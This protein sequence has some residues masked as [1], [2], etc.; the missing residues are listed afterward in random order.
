M[1][2]NPNSG[3]VRLCVDYQRVNA[4]TKKDRHPLPLIQECFD[5][6]RDAKFFSKIDLQQ[7]FHQMRIADGDVPKTA[8]GTKYGHFEWLVMPFGLVNAPS[9]FQRMM[10]QILREF[11]DIFVQVYLDDILIYSRNKEDHL[12]HVEQ[13]LKVRYVRNIAKIAA[14]LHN[15]TAGGVLKW[16]AVSWFP[17]HTVAFAQLK[18]ALMSGPVLLMPNTQSPFVM[19][20]D[21]LDFA[22]G[23]VWLQNG[24]DVLLHPVA[25]ESCKLNKAQVDYP[26]QERELLAIIHAWRKWHVYLD[27]AVE[28]TIVYTDHASLK[29]LSTQQLPLKRICRW[30]EEFSKMD[31]EIRYKKGK[32]NVVPDALSRQGDLAVMEEIDGTLHWSDW[33]LIIP[34]LIEKRE[35][36]SEVPHEMTERA[37]RNLKFFE[38]N[39][40]DKTL[41]YLGHPGLRERL[42]FVA[43]AYCYNLL[44]LVHND[45][46]HQGRDSTLQLLRGREWWPK[47][48][49][50]VN[51]YVHTCAACQVHKRPHK[52][53]ETGLQKPLPVV[54]PFERWS[55]DLIQ[56]PKSYKSGYKWILTVVDPCTSWPV[57]V[58]L[59][60]A[61]AAE[62]AQAI[63][64][65]VVTPFGI[66]KE[67][68]TDRVSNFL[69]SGFLQ[70]LEAAGVK[71]LNTAGY[72]P[73]TNGKCERYN[74]ILEAALFRMNTTGDPSNWEDFLAPAL[75]ST[76]IHTSGSSRFSP[77]KL[78]Y[79]V[80]P[81]LPSDRK[82][83]VAAQ[84]VLPGEAELA[85]CIKEL[86]ATRVVSAENT[87]KRAEASK[88]AFDGKSKFSRDL[89][90][91]DV[92]HIR[93]VSLCSLIVNNMWAAP[94][95][96]AQR[97]KR[98]EAKVAKD[99]IQKTK[100]LSKVKTIPAAATPTRR[101]KLHL[102]PPP[103]ISAGS[104]TAPG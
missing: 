49:E 30:I 9:T 8:F 50:D 20:T 71:K 69:S 38:Y 64:D 59:K 62:L 76:R 104:G 29:Y 13:V 46:G 22:V 37:K 45:M 55:L 79:G 80:K 87:A 47:Q 56:M 97:E 24:E 74:G 63:F 14:P 52:H 36:P 33:P 96:I 58:P 75:F 57:A 3:K 5:S 10:T 88:V 27:G 39:K 81:R 11:I 66:P 31:L 25:F 94:P 17:V 83:M 16:Q 85:N 44:R 21:A 35:L 82:R 61:T 84:P 42:P 32:D 93:P 40:K 12:H 98:K 26:A 1:V 51:S 41:T 2:K 86:N 34:Y 65:Q 7:G 78:L 19:E 6:L 102:G 43:H 91:L 67:F 48:Y 68:L 23:E 99:L 101:L 54:G 90:I 15:L 89:H 73:Q 72:H 77:F 100:K 4:L 53:Q 60:E 95:A 103:G 28:T 18:E 70:F 92:G